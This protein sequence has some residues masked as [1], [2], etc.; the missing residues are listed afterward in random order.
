MKKENP[1]KGQK[2]GFWK[3]LGWIMTYYRLQILCVLAAISVAGYIIYINVRPQRTVILN[4]MMVNGNTSAE[5]DLFD[6]YLSAA[7][8]NT[9]EDTAY[10]S[11]GIQISFDGSDAHAWDYFEVVSAQFL[12]GDIDLFFSNGEVFESF[13]N[14]GAFLDVADYLTPEEL[15][16]YQDSILYVTN[17][18][19]GEQMACGLILGPET[20]IRQELYFL[21]TC[22]LGMAANV[23]NDDE[24]RAVLTEIL[25]ELP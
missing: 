4:V 21:D 11:N 10:V 6:R 7:G 23:Y 9:A 25:K 3:R 20:Q 22:Y 24:A 19:T 12:T 15:E 18:K 13:A 16:R 17:R 8:Y 2:L 5:S 1:Y 14:Y